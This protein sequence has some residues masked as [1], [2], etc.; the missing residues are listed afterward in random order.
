MPL[1]IFWST[2]LYMA[3]YVMVKQISAKYPE[4]NPIDRKLLALHYYAAS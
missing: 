3:L 2:G 4:A 1:C